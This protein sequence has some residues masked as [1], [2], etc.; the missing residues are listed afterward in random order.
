MAKS[1]AVTKK[2]KG[3]SPAQKQSQAKIAKVNKLA[4]KNIYAAGERGTA[5]PTWKSALKAAAKQ[6]YKK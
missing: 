2:K 6:V 5:V 3:P 4:V 1:K